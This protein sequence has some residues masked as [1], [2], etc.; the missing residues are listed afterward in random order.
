MSAAEG[1][2]ALEQHCLVLAAALAGGS[3]IVLQS[4]L[5]RT[6]AFPGT[7]SSLGSGVNCVTAGSGLVLGPA[8][9]VLRSDV[10]AGGAGAGAAP[11]ARDLTHRS[12]RLARGGEQGADG[13]AG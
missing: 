3:R 12:G 6:A 1:V 11:C 2:P 4:P 8:A 7:S 5:G 10:M 13:R 9:P